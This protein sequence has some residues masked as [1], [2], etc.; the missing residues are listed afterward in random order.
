MTYQYEQPADV[1]WE[2]CRSYN[3]WLADF[4]RLTPGRRAGVGLIAVDDIDQAVGEIEWLRN[5]DVF[6]GIILPGDTNGHAFYNHPRYEPIWSACEDLD[7]PIHTHSGWTPNYGDLPGSLGIF[8]YEIGWYAHRP[9]HH[10]I[11]SGAFERHPKLKFVMTEQ[12]AT[13]VV[14]ALQQLDQQYQLPM[15]RHMR[16]EL[17]REPSEYFTSN[18]FIGAAF[19]DGDAAEARYDI[20]VDKLMW[21]SDYPHLEGTWPHTSESL[22]QALGSVPA[23]EVTQIL[24]ATAA[25]VYDFD[26][27]QLG[28]LAAELGPKRSSIGT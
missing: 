6:G 22:E 4:C 14:Q 7:M 24:G 2:G 20:G 5:N 15:F 11:W 1:W 17:P 9:M 26:A 8:L 10:L 3:R 12:G 16:R 18:C 19:L 25:R 27:E 13:W 23:D 28:E 21:G